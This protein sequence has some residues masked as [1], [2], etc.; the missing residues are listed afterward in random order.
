MRESGIGKAGI[1]TRKSEIV[2]LPTPDSRLPFILEIGTEE[3][4]VADV[5]AAHAQLAEQ[6]PALLD[7][8]HLE[9]GDVRVFSTPRRL[10][11]SVANLS[12]RQPDRE[13]LIKGPPADKAIDVSRTGSPTYL[14]A[15][16]GFA[17]KN[18]VNTKDLQVR[19]ENGG[20]YVF[21]VVK[22]KGRSTPEV[23][24]E[25]LP[26]LVASIKFEKSMK[27]NE[28]GVVFSLSDSLVCGDARRSG[29]SIRVC[30]RCFK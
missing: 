27:W 18:G 8:L 19:E 16:L 9:H 6:I 23:L 7:E 15:A 29:D 25:A 30:W 26:N 10:V 24:A 2:Q 5:D 4:P 1:G 11:V 20:K 28:S 13:D 3:L 14:P 12:P 17:K 22:Q 21:A